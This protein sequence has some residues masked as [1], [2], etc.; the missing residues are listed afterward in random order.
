[1]ARITVVG[2]G[3]IGLT[4][5][6]ALREA[7][8]DVHIIAAAWGS[9]ITSAAAGAIWFPFR[10]DPAPIINR[11]AATTRRWQESLASR[12]P[13][14]GIDVLT[15]EVQ[16][17]SPARPWWADAIDDLAPPISGRPEAP[18]IWRFKAPRIEPAL[19]CGWFERS[20]KGRLT[21]RTLTSPQELNE[22]GG[23]LIINCTGIG[24]RTLCN[25]RTLQGVWG[26]TTI[27]ATDGIDCS[28]S[29]SD[30]RD[31]SQFYYSI[32]RRNEVVLGGCALDRPGEETDPPTAEMRA[33]ILA[34]AAAHGI[35]SPR[36]LRDSSGLRPCRPAVRLE[37]EGRIIHNYG[38]GG[39][40]YTLCR[41]CAM[42]VVA[43]A[44]K[45]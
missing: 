14:L 13:E 34:R 17:D 35:A 30:E 44:A 23:D 20:F 1:M 36:F 3:V 8:H 43:L 18:Y 26:Q 10:S 5:A 9:H 32:P 24:S 25:D 45:G 6:D 7:G 2:A 42:D 41:G 4:T 21:Q 16:T 37:R 31:E 29:I 22:L 39:S 40:G 27:V 33:T 11:W 19:F 12:I 15:L 38:H 28:T